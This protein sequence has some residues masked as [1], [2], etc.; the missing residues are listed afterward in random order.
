MKPD[1]VPQPVRTLKVRRYEPPFRWQVESQSNPRT[2]HL[3]DLLGFHGNGECSCP[4]FTF[5]LAREL[6]M[7]RVP[8]PA[9]RC[10]HI[11]AAREALLNTLIKENLHANKNH[12]QVA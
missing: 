8:S 1:L 11:R 4:H 12:G 6:R 9:T 5:T 10:K 7:G 3:V 2:P